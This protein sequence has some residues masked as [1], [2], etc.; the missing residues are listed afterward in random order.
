MSILTP[1][2]LKQKIKSI[3]IWKKGDERAPHK[4]ILILY[5]LGQL[6][7]KGERQLNYEYVREDLTD[8]LDEFGPPR[9][10]THPEQPFV[11]LT[12]DTIWELNK[13]VIDQNIRDSWLRKNQVIGRFNEET[14]SL[15]KNNNEL[16][17]EIAEILLEQYFP[18]TLHDDILMAVGLDFSSNYNKTRDPKFRE[19]I[20]RAYERKCAVCGFNIRLKN[21]LVAVEAAHIK[22]HHYGGPDIENNGVALCTMHHKL[23]DKGVFTIDESYKILVSEDAFGDIGFEEWLM[24]FH[25]NTIRVPIRTEY[26]PSKKY[27]NWHIREVFKDPARQ[28]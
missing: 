22:W 25:R 28:Y 6:Q 20:L 19:K 21:K 1:D 10:K 24:R 15:L 16:I 18:D 3:K 11:R 8:L 12:K 9:K 7:S 17:K 26:Y 5:A 13:E 2:E 27:M 23:Y 4:P 14:Y